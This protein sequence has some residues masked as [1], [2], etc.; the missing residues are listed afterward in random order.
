MLEDRNGEQ[1]CSRQQKNET[2][3]TVYPD[4]MAWFKPAK[5]QP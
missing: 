4:Q 3:T 2:G 5:N 1:R